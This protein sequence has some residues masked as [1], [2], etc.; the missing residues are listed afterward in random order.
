MT[1][2]ETVGH[3]LYELREEHLASAKKLV[4]DG[5]T[6][7]RV[8]ITFNVRLNDDAG[9]LLYWV[10]QNGVEIGRADIQMDE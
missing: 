2:L 1:G 6:Y 9:H 10:M 8:A 7:Y 3:V 5:K 4:R